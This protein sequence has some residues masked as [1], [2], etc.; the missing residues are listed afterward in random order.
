MPEIFNISLS[1]GNVNMKMLYEEDR[2][3]NYVRYILQLNQREE[4]I[5]EFLI[6][7][8]DYPGGIK[9]NGLQQLLLSKRGACLLGCGI[10]LAGEVLDCWAKNNSWSDFIDCLKGKGFKLIGGTTACVIKCLML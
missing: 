6:A 3:N 5:I 9:I 4:Y 1:E 7:V 10:E 8:D 2:N